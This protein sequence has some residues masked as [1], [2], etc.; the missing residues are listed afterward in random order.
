MK[1][2]V[3]EEEKQKNP[4]LIF[5]ISLK[6]YKIIY[7]QNQD[8]TLHDMNIVGDKNDVAQVM[9]LLII[10]ISVAIKIE[11]YQK[12]DEVKIIQKIIDIAVR[13]KVNEICNAIRIND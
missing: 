4:E 11:T 12:E 2:D 9:Q 3:I 7:S 13:L 8:A 1:A 5:F 10:K 6:I